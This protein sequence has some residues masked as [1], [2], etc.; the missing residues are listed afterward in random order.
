M[1]SRVIVLE[2]N[3][4]CPPLLDRFMAAG[5]LPS[6]SR[7][8]QESVVCTTD[9]QEPQSFLNPWIQWITAHTGVGY[10]EH[11]VF[12]LG[13]GGQLQQQ[14]VADVVT[15]HGGDVWLCGPMNVVPRR[16]MRGWWLPDPWNP[17]DVPQPVELAPFTEFVR[18]SV[19]EH[20]N[21]SHRL[22]PRACVRFLRTMARHGLTRS[23]VRAA[24]DQLV[25]ERTGR[26]E[27]WRR[28]A[29]LD[30]FQWD[31]FADHWREARPLLATYFSNTTAH[32]QHVYWRHM[33]PE[34]FTIKPS[35][36]EQAR[37]GPAVH[38]GYLEMDRLVGEAL[39]LAGDDTVL[40]LCTAL[41]QQPYL[42]KEEEGGNRFHRPHDLG[43]VLARLGV[44]GVVQVAPV[45]AAQFHVYFGNEA[46]AG[47][48]A[49][50]LAGATVDG[51]PA[52]DVRH[53]GTD[54]FTGIAFTDDVEPD[55]VLRAGDRSVPFEAHFYRAETAKSGYHHP[56][57]AF[58]VRIPGR[59]PTVLEEPVSLRAVAPTM[60][61]LLGLP[62][63]PT[64]A[65]APISAV[66][67]TGILA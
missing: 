7:L 11:G 38:S 31:L 48:A 44:A 50:M 59:P 67:G 2:L 55:A 15:A 45:M 1:V 63:A 52:F 19:Q 35:P 41:S 12:K 8:H 57:G 65:E 54:V 16:S 34:P 46:D 26:V 64:M 51:R 43:D 39:D 23:T 6:F 4:L 22:S 32:Y 24:I 20:T 10:E 5:D 9:A 58:W 49:T 30:R 33:D 36:E 17:Q 3:E 14:T 25:G 66:V 29:L 28:A 37:F 56:Q 60:L 27:R 13:E 61:A 62:P 21:D 42:L 18:A 40:V 53:V 47:A